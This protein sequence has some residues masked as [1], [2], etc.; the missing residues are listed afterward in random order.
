MKEISYRKN[1]EAQALQYFLINQDYAHI[2]KFAQVIFNSSSQL[3]L[4]IG[5]TYGLSDQ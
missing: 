2:E 4:V 5:G 3:D 1:L